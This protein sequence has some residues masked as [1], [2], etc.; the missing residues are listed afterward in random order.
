MKFSDRSYSKIQGTA[1]VVV[2]AATLAI[3]GPANAQY[4]PVGKDGIAAS[5]RVR[6]QLDERKARVEKTSA[7]LPS[8]GCTK[9]KH[10]SDPQSGG[11]GPKEAEARKETGSKPLR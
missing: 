5:P 3:P 8:Q 10:P 9:C 6:Q 4:K 11:A 2:F 7:T 1:L